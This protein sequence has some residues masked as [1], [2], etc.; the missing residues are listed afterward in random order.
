VSFKCS[1][2]VTKKL[3]TSF[4]SG[5]HVIT[6]HKRPF[7]AFYGLPL[8]D[9]IVDTFHAYDKEELITEFEDEYYKAQ[10]RYQF[11]LILNSFQQTV[12]I[13]H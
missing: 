9:E 5:I 6:R 11:K 3:H 12:T 7:I 13:Q 2:E 8:V 10:K 4:I 1:K